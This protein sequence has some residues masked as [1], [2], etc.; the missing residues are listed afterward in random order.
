MNYRFNKKSVPAVIILSLV[1]CGIYYFI[2]VAQTTDILV[3]QNRITRSDRYPSENFD[4]SG[5]M[6]VL[7]TIIT[8]GIYG[9]YWWYKVGQVINN[10]QLRE[11]LRFATDNSIIYLLL[12][13]FQCSFVGM[14]ILQSDLNNTWD[15]LDNRYIYGN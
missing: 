7:L 3:T 5:G 8:C 2:W 15:Y 11:D 14:A 10:I 12:A 4:I 13:L 6:V 9:L 1:T